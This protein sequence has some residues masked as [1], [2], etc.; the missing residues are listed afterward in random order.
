MSAPGAQKSSIRGLFADRTAITYY[1]G[2]HLDISNI[3]SEAV[4]FKQTLSEVKLS[5]E[6]PDFP[7]YPYGSLDN[8][9]ILNE[10]LR[11]PHRDLMALAS[12]GR[13]LDIG[14]ADGE[15]SF[16]MAH[17]G[18][19]VDIVDH[20]P[21]N[22]NSLRGARALAAHFNN[23]V[24]VFDADLDNHFALPEPNYSLGF[25]LGILYHL[26]NPYLVL[27]RLAQRCQWLLISTRVVAHNRG[28]E[29]SAT[30][31]E[32]GLNEQQ[33]TLRGIP[34]A[35]LVD[36]D[37][38][39]RDATN[40]WMFTAAGVERLAHRTG[41]DVLESKSFGDLEQSNPQDAAH[42][43]RYFALLKSRHI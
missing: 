2:A 34:A 33:V 28:P 14:A 37:E 39:N 21:T 38:C 13:V 31:T 23:G 22:F 6:A 15:M 11:E 20:A 16:L 25:F 29:R 12:G 1:C 26:K 7:W 9:W 18:C 8:F 17:L 27:D 19:Q 32:R 40:F 5:V 42:D 24:R 4:T 30:D 36:A 43:E 10:F 41:W 35:Y 3:W